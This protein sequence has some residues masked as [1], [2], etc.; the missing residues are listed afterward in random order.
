MTTSTT[1]AALTLLA[2]TL[3]AATAALPVAP[4]HERSYPATAS[5][6]SPEPSR[7]V[8]FRSSGSMKRVRRRSPY[9]FPDA[10]SAIR[11]RMM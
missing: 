10:C 6:P 5:G 4:A 2:T 7:Y 1:R 3:L 11:P 9:G 8:R